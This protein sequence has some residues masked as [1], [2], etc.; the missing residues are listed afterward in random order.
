VASSP[1]HLPLTIPGFSHH[2]LNSTRFIAG[3]Y[4]SQQVLQT[5]SRLAKSG[6][7]GI[8]NITA[9]GLV[10][11]VYPVQPGCGAEAISQALEAWRSS[12]RTGCAP[13]ASLV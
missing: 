8:S 4:A 13:A 1:S 6:I 5:Y 3:H 12:G 11:Q 2:V 10:L 9:G 7:N